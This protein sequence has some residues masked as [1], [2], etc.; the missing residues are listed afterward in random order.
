MDK[1]KKRQMHNFIPQD[2]LDL[3]LYWLI[4]DYFRPNKSCPSPTCN[5]CALPIFSALRLYLAR[6]VHHLLHSHWCTMCI[7]LLCSVEHHPVLSQSGCPTH[8]LRLCLL[9]TPASWRTIWCTLGV[10]ASTWDAGVWV[11]DQ[12]LAADHRCF[13]LVVEPAWL[14]YFLRYELEKRLRSIFEVANPVASESST[15]S[16][17]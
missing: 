3:H 5:N 13:I 9:S 12:L 14:W 6:L 17:K 16:S 10:G 11:L 2:F 1:H 15:K 8:L 4:V 7:V